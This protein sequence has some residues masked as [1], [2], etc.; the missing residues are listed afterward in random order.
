MI[1][2]ILACIFLAISLAPSAQGKNKEINAILT[3]E[4]VLQDPIVAKGY[5]QFQ[6]INLFL[7]TLVR[8]DPNIGLVSGVAKRW[9]VSENQKTYTFFLS[10]KARFHNEDPVKADDI[11]FSFKRHL[12]PES[13]S[14]VASY[15]HNILE[16]V[17][18][19]DDV[20]VR[21]KLKGP[22][23][24]FLELLS[25]SGFGIISQKSTGKSIIGSGP[26]V[27]EVNDPAKWCLKKSP[28]YPFSS[29]NIDRYCFQIERD[30]EKTVD[31]LNSRN[32]NL[33]MGSPLE[34]ALSKGLKTDLVSNPTFSLVSTH[35]FINHTKPFFKK[36]EN[37]KLIA[38]IAR[39]AR[40]QKGILTKFDAPLDTYLPLGIMPESYYLPVKSPDRLPKI[41]KKEQISLVFPYGIFLEE[42]VEK[43]VNTFKSAGFD[44]TYKNVKGKDLLQPIMDGNFDLVFIPYQGVISDPDGYLDMLNPNSVLKKAQIPSKD[45]LKNLESIRFMSGKSE[46]LK[47]YQEEFKKWEASFSVIPFSQNSIPIVYNKEIQL[48]NLNY[49]F[50]LNLREL[51]ISHGK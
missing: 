18:K 49:T 29:S 9:S 25:M 41:K 1:N 15:L 48:P 31:K 42:S 6:V 7:D 28:N 35:I 44:V 26:Y 46:R 32:V 21:F 16:D 30:A 50:H 43:I 38:D 5:Q 4:T 22:Y 20:T 51:S 37:R 27:F 12:A 2:R 45:L 14:A 36:I 3:T 47:K 39:F 34:V 8:K 40:D 19:V 24:P 33:A 10:E 17:N 13:G 23:P 11:L